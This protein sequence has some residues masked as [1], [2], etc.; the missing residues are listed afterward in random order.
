MRTQI[1]VSMMALALASCG[2]DEEA[3]FRCDITDGSKNGGIVSHTE[4]V[5]E[6]NDGSK[7]RV[8]ENDR[9]SSCMFANGTYIIKASDGTY[10]GTIGMFKNATGYSSPQYTITFSSAEAFQNGK[11]YTAT[12]WKGGVADKTAGKITIEDFDPDNSLLS[13]T[14][15][16]EIHDGTFYPY[17]SGVAIFDKYIMIEQGYFENIE[18]T[19]DAFSSQY[20]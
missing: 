5:N 19:F 6:Y 3:M 10:K 15:K 7:K 1:L 13:I 4:K 12:F 2:G 9:E 14:F 20:E 8:K 16:G 18:F 11:T 17:S